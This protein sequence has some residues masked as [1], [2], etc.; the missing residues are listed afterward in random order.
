MKTLLPC[1]ALFA[2]FAAIGC[3]DVDEIAGPP[4]KAAGPPGMVP[5]REGMVNGRNSVK[6]IMPGA[7]ASGMTPMSGTESLDGTTGG[8]VA[9]AA[10]QRARDM[11]ASGSQPSGM[12][13]VE[14]GDNGTPVDEGST[15][16]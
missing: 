3:H 6:P 2:A 9:D 12:A 4:G 10:K 11:A 15:G 8:G 14:P 16:Q 7:G 1:L 13:P 5:G